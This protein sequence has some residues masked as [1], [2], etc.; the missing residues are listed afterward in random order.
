MQHIAKANIYEIQRNLFE[1]LV[2]L[3]MQLLD[4]I[5]NNSSCLK[6]TS[7]ETTRPQQEKRTEVETPVQSK[8]CPKKEEEGK[9]QPQRLTQSQA[10]H[11]VPPL[12][13]DYAKVELL[14]R[15]LVAQQ[16]Q[17]LEQRRLVRLA[18]ARKQ[19]NFELSN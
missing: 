5:C 8:M 6:T 18:I 11:K 1:L 7:E 16:L 10:Q 9:R 12:P 17:Q 3:L 2:F 13:T 14:H 4:T 15:M 19:L